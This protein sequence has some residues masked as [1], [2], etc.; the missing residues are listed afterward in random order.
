MV[1]AMTALAGQYD[2]AI[3]SVTGGDQVAPAATVNLLATA[4]S[5]PQRAMTQPYAGAAMFHESN[6]ATIGERY[7][8]S[9]VAPGA[10]I[11][12]LVLDSLGPF[13]GTILVQQ[14]VTF[15][16]NTQN[17]AYVKQASPM[18]TTA[19]NAPTQRTAYDFEIAS[20]SR[21][22]T[23][24]RYQVEACCGT[25]AMAIPVADIETL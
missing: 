8:I 22:A 15:D 12:T 9:V 21:A 11:V 10:E 5:L 14:S 2:P 19:P 23:T 17:G 6:T 18:P 25:M 20:P 7:L 16:A 13:A 24:D 3:E 1:D 4:C